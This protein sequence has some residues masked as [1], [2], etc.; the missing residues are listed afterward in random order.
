MIHV[1]ASIQIKPGNKAA[2]LDIFKANVSAVKAEDGCIE[3]R[4]TVDVET[5]MPPQRLEPDT[6]VIIEKWSTLEA[7]RAHLATPHMATYRQ[8]VKALVEGVSLKVLQDA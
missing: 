7:L 3:Y 8:K 2:F 6:V 5:G 4:P 1:I